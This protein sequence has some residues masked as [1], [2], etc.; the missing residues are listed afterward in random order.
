MGSRG[1][2]SEKK[3]LEKLKTELNAIKGVFTRMK[4]E[5]ALTAENCTEDKYTKH[6]NKHVRLK[7]TKL[8]AREKEA[9]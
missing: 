6:R 8:A 7:A 1:R 3:V 9:A 4:A 2:N 5:R